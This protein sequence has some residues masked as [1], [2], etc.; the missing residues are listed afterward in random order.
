[1][2]GCISGIGFRSA[3]AVRNLQDGAAFALFL[4]RRRLD[5]FVSGTIPDDSLDSA[6][7]LLQVGQVDAG[8][9]VVFVELVLEGVGALL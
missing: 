7:G 6:E 5:I 3:F 4:N 9:G 1:M 2:A 8:H